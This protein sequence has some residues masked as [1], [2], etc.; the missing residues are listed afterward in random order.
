MWHAADL[1]GDTVPEV[2]VGTGGAMPNLALLSATGDVLWRIS[3]SSPVGAVASQDLDGDGTL[4]VVVGMASGAI[5]VYDEHGRLRARAHAGLPVWGLEASEDGSVL[6]PSL[7]LLFFAMLSP[8]NNGNIN[9]VIFG[10]RTVPC[11][12]SSRY[13]SG[14]I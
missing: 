5:E 9:Y 6:V 12:I 14:I 2:V 3:V 1:S 13:G 8:G 11:Y 10:L 7:F 4:E